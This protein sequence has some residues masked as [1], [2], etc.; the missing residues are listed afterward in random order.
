MQKD[1]DDD[2]RHRLLAPGRSSPD[3]GEGPSVPAVPALKPVEV[4]YCGGTVSF[5][6]RGAGRVASLVGVH[7]GHVA[8]VCGVPPEYC[9]YGPTFEQCKVWIL[10]NC[11][12]LLP[13]LKEEAEKK[14]AEKKAAAAA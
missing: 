12:E 6:F 2:G 4:T 9:E 13:G 14:E 3:A 1:D 10:K 8:S 11:P 5:L 7:F